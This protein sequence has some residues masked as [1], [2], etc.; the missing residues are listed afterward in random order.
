MAKYPAAIKELISRAK[1]MGALDAK[2][3]PTSDVFTAPWVRW[4]CQFGCGGYG[5]SL[6]CPPFSPTPEQTRATLDSYRIALLLHSQDGERLKE[7]AVALEREAFLA[8][9]YKAF[10]MGNGPCF[11]CS[12]CT[13]DRNNCRHPQEA[14]PAMEACG[15]DVFRTARTAGFPI[16]VVRGTDEEANF[17]SLVLVE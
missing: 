17:Y 5:N 14:R 4:K 16:E 2:V 12:K 11:L 9:F 13:L 6:T 3:I 1:K 15:I 8:G 10:A 7:I